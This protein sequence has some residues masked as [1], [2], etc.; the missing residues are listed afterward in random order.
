MPGGRK[1]SLEECILSFFV[2]EAQLG[3]AHSCRLG[4]NMI[5]TTLILLYAPTEWFSLLIIAF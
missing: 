5:K 4:F 2:L 3:S 1:E